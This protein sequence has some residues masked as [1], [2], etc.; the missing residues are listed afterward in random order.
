MQ[1]AGPLL[2][3]GTW[4]SWMPT[5]RAVQGRTMA[6]PALEDWGLACPAAFADQDFPAE[7]S[8][9]SLSSAEE[10]LESWIFFLFSVSRSRAGKNA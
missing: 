4:S 5:L 2:P 8:H 6:F 1:A 10:D 9:C 3:H 7:E